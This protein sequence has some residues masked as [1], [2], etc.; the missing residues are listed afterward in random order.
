MVWYRMYVCTYL[1]AYLYTYDMHLLI[2]H[3]QHV[4]QHAWQRRRIKPNKIK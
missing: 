2:R 3:A 4:F 1:F